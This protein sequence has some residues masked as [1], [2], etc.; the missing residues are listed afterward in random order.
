MIAPPIREHEL[1][2]EYEHS[3]F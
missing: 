2:R 3:W 1:I